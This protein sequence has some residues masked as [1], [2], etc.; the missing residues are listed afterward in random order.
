MR[1]NTA[2]MLAFGVGFVSLSI[3]ILWVRLVSFIHLGV[4]QAFAFVLTV[5]LSGV[6]L[7]AAIGKRLCFNATYA[8]GAAGFFIFLAGVVDV[9]TPWVVMVSNS[10][11]FS[12][13]LTV[14]LILSS[15][16]LKAVI[17]PIA[18]YLGSSDVGAQLGRS[19]SRVYF[20]NILGATLGPVFTGFY[21]LDHV[22]LQS[23][24][25]VLGLFCL[26]VG[27]LLWARIC[28]AGIF[29][30]LAG[31][32]VILI[33]FIDLRSS[34]LVGSLSGAGDGVRFVVENKQGIIHTVVGESET[35]GD[36]VFGGNVY[37]GRTSTN[38]VVNS[39]RI[40]RAYLLS[41]LVDSP[42]KILVL[43][44]STGAWAR[45]VSAIP[46]VERVDV[47]EINP[48]YIDLIKKYPSVSPLL[49]DDRVKI[50]IDDGRRWLRRHPSEQYDL[51]VMNTS[52]HWR[53]NSTNLLS[54]EFLVE[55]EKHMLPGAILAFNSTRSPDVMLTAARV[56][57][58]VYRWS[59]FIYCSDF[60]FRSP[61]LDLQ[62]RRLMSLKLDGKALLDFGNIQGEQAFE[63][64]VTRQF[65]TLDQVAAEA[66]RALEVV[67]D[68]NMIT[69]Y[70][71]GM[72][73]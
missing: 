52:F 65:E 28:L 60:D 58:N 30:F 16:T 51:I 46:S 68:D 19:L 70:K 39:N 13:L 62:R 61:G 43:G 3:E 38:L 64:L 14:L 42:K 23:C 5:F 1:K 63:R 73:F 31:L 2:W 32:T 7:G 12:Y 45:V 24:F 26:M 8:L 17:F 18:H 27:L 55:L 53:A 44:L 72:G 49:M 66:G 25:I 50:N 69:E 22:S 21:L 36:I 59:N 15:A 47:V 6:A 37:D 40:D 33:F 54:Q 29:Y 71:Y 41:S 4:P 56:F 57:K 10:G 20:F 35:E 48:G 34:A 11:P 67:T 9:I